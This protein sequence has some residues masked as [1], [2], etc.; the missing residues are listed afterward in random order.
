LNFLGKAK[1]GVLQFSYQN[2]WQEQLRSS[3]IY[4]SICKWE[5][6]DVLFLVEYNKGTFFYETKIECG[7]DCFVVKQL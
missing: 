1:I 4:G 6:Y 3:G 7:K 5:K 2:A